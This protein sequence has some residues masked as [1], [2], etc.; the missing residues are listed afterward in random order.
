LFRYHPIIPFK[1]REE[2]AQQIAWAESNNFRRNQYSLFSRNCE[3]F[4]NMIVYGVNQSE[5]TE[6]DRSI[7]LENEI[8]RTNNSLE[9]TS[10]FRSREVEHQAR[11]E[12]PSKECNTR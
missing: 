11:I 9:K 10:N 4:A 6:G 8:N 5:Q 2:I 7:I 12:V 3:H 1:H